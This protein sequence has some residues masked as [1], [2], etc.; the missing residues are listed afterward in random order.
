MAAAIVRAI[1]AALE[2]FVLI[3][4]HL[5]VKLVLIGQLVLYD[6]WSRELFHKI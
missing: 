6:L 1:T 4:R 5:L 3:I 2:K